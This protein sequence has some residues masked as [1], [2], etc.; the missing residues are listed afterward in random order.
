[1]VEPRISAEIGF[2]VLKNAGGGVGWGVG[3]IHKG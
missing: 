1:M 2:D 3:V